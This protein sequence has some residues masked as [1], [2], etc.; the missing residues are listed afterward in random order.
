VP[1]PSPTLPPSPTPARLGEVVERVKQ[2][3]VLIWTEGPDGTPF[4]FGTGVSLGGG[5]VLTAYHVIHDAPQPWVRFTSGRDERVQVVAADPR[6][7]LALL[8]SSFTGEP[9]A[10]IG[11]VAALRQG[12]TLIAVGYPYAGVV[13]LGEPTV[14]NGIF[15]ARRQI[16]GV[17]YVQTNTSL[18]PGNSGGPVTDEQGR[19]VGVVKGELFAAPGLHFAI[20]SDEVQAFLANTSAMPPP[21][22]PSPLPT[23]TRVPTPAP[24]ATVR[25]T[26]RPTPAPV[27]PTP[28]GPTRLGLQI[29]AP[30]NGARIPERVVI[31][32]LQ[33]V[34]TPPG[35]HVWLFVRAQV[36]GG[37]W[38]PCPREI[39]AGPDLTWECEVY[40]GGPPEVRHVILAGVADEAAHA[41][42]SRHLAA[43]PN[44]PLYPEEQA[45]R[46]PNG[47]RGEAEVEV[48]RS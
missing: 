21:P 36:P 24:T 17:W 18:N 48:V 10:P 19:L 23:A 14:T 25:P 7:D 30:P 27:P 15:S 20:A 32:G 35:T 42:L 41:F 2:Y 5:S 3:T 8:R 1:S 34:R 43:N 45:P 46:L 33:S 47:F 26:V 28:S 40:L 38:Y 39:V 29:T 13:G 37:R 31:R 16:Q 44:Q 9:A 11:E 6:R 12:D 4:S 22:S